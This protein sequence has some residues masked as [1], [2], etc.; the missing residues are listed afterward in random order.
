MLG[1]GMRRR[2]LLQAATLPRITSRITSAVRLKR[3]I[4]GLMFIRNA[5]DLRF[6]DITPKSL[7]LRRREFLQT[8]AGAAIGAAAAVA[9]PFAAR[10]SA[11]EQKAGTGHGAKLANVKKSPLST[12]GEKVTSFD[13]ITS[14]NN[15]YE[16]GPYKEDPKANAWRLKPRPWTITIDGYAEKKGVF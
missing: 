12:T 3:P 4:I 2:R 14:Y 7:Y 9:S 11:Q 6:S 15:F 10:V 16:Y 5:P 1:S 8:A 13:D